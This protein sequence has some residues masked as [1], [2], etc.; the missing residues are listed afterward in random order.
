MIFWF[1]TPEPKM[2]SECSRFMQYILHENTVQI[3][4]S[5]EGSSRFSCKRLLLEGDAGTQVWSWGVATRLAAVA[6][7]GPSQGSE[8]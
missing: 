8:L 4:L 6:Q 2:S 7:L 3:H 1:I 5:A